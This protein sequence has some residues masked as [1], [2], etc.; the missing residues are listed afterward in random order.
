MYQASA[1]PENQERSPLKKDF[2][3][4]IQNKEVTTRKISA[5]PGSE[6]IIFFVFPQKK[7]V[8]QKL[9]TKITA[10]TNKYA[11]IKLIKKVIFPPASD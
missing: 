8:K 10:A 4:T 1:Q 3:N 2:K 5:S 9:K 11:Y 6:S 7:K